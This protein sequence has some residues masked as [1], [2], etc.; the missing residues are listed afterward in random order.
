[1]TIEQVKEQLPSVKLFRCGK[2]YNATVKGRKLPFAMVCINP[3]DGNK[4]Y[5][6]SWEFSWASITRA[7]NTD[8]PLT[9]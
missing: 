1:M 7:I 9:L 4:D 6:L 3:Q 2:T 5:E 8:T